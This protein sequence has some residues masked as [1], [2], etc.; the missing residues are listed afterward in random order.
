MDLRL[1]I[2]MGSVLPLLLGSGA[3]P[4]Q[5]LRSG[6]FEVPQLAAGEFRYLNV[7]PGWFFEGDAGI[8]SRS[9]AF[10]AGTPEVPAGQQVAFVQCNGRLR[11]W[12]YLRRHAVLSFTATQRVNHHAK[13][14]Q[15]SVLPDG[16]EQNFV[17][18]D[19]QGRRVEQRITPRRV[20]T[21]PATRCS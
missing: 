19:P 8:S 17:L 2:G 18:G 5:A 1:W 12:V 4:A 14:Q 21:T 13:L 11:Q 15:L 6:S 7:A 9:S 3:S 10:T 16:V 20:T